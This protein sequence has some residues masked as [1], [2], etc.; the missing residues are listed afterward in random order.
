MSLFTCPLCVVFIEIKGQSI[1]KLFSTLDFPECKDPSTSSTTLRKSDILQKIAFCLNS[2]ESGVVAT[3]YVD[4]YE[5]KKRHMKGIWEEWLS[6]TSLLEVKIIDAKG[7][8]INDVRTRF[9]PHSRT[10][11]FIT[12]GK[13]RMHRRGAS[14]QILNGS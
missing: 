12:R 3:D 4:V 13:G 9:I 1:L 11:S 2:T 5:K 7:W 8:Y 10:E 6:S 14:K